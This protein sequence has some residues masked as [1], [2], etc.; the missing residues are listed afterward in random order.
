[1][2]PGK[3]ADLVVLDANPLEN[4]RNSTSARW[5]MVNGRVFESLTMNEVGRTPRPRAPFWFEGEGGQTWGAA[6]AAESSGHTDD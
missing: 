2:E 1:L 5:V 4:L 3:L 6:A